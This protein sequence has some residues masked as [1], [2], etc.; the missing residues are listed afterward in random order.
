YSGG[1]RP[2]FPEVMPEDVKLP[3]R[4]TL[5]MGEKGIILNRGGERRPEIFPESLRQSYTP[6]KPSLTRSNGH[7]RDWVDA[8]KGWPEASSNF[9]YGADLTEITLLGVLSLRLGGKKINWD[10]KNMKAV[11]LPA[12]DAII[13]EPI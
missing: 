11:G 4:G 3:S 8:G 5:F 13:R 6:P 9:S 10:S 12:A 1:L 2:Q 7:Y